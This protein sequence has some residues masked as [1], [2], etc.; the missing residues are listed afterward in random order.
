VGHFGGPATVA[1]LVNPLGRE[2]VQHAPV[3]ETAGALVWRVRSGK[4]QVQLVHRPKY[5]DWSW[6][7]GKLEEGEALATAAAREVAEETGKA[8]LLGLPLPGLQY[9]TPEGRVKRVHYWAARRAQPRHDSQALAARPPVPPVRRDEV[10]KQVWLD[11]DEAA[12]RL[13]RSSDRGPL[14]ALVE[15]YAEGRLDTHVVAIVRHGR[16]LSRGVW[17]GIDRDRPLTPLGHAQAAAI[18]PLLSAYGV[19]L[20]L[21]SRWE[22]CATSIDPYVRASGLRPEYSDNLSEAQHERSPSRVAATV[23]ELLEAGRSSVLCTHRPVLPT[24]LDV[25]GQHSRRAIAN[26]LPARDPFLELGEILIAHVAATGKGPR[27]VGVEKIT[28]PVY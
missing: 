17:H 18:V 15:A 22:R 24:V 16:A 2:P 4:L 5:D 10:D 3:I 1:P 23:R 8:V 25:L 14:E 6:P 7:K 13:T 26:V 27:V 21:S 28:P 9:L 11:A 19:A 20:V 12:V